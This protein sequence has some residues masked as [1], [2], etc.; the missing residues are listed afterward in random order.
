MRLGVMQP[1]FLPYLG[2]YQLMTSVDLFIYYDDVTYIKQGWV[3]RNYIALNNEDFR[4]TLELSGASSFKKINEI[5]IGRNREKLLKTFVQAYSKYPYYQ[6][7]KILLYN[8][9][10]DSEPN[11]FKYIYQTNRKIFNYLKLN[12]N[13]LVSSE[14]EKS[15]DLRGQAKV[16]DI[17]KRLGTAT[18][19]NAIGGQ[20]L[21]SK[22]DF[23]HEGIELLFIDSKNIPKRSVIDVLMSY[24]IKE[25][26]N[27]LCSYELV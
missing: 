1:Y 18:Y 20:R 5:G 16:L 24:S 4:F 2:Y 8:I 10:I 26:K 25:I 6:D 14:M 15:N 11:L 21:Y 9:F 12:I 22:E 23:K 3:N 7:V 27:M 17:C 19:I 13:C